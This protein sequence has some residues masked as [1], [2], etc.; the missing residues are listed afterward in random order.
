MSLPKKRKTNIQIKS[1]N[2]D[3]GPA[4]WVEQFIDQN[5]QFL[6]RSV[7]HEDL[8]GGL[9]NFI[10]KDLDLSFDNKVPVIFLTAQRWS[11]FAK[12]WRFVDKYKNIKIPF[13]SI[14]RKPDAQPGTNPADFKIPIRK[15]FPYM[16]IPVWDGN[17]KG[18]DIYRIPNPVGVDLTYTVRFF[19]YKMRQ[20]NTFN[21]MILQAFASAQAYINV[22][23]HYFPIMLESIGDESTVDGIEN[24]RFY[25]QTYEMKLM[26]YLVDE[27]EFDVV[28]AINRIVVTTEVDKKKPKAIVNFI[29][30]EDE[31]DKTVS[32]IIQFLPG[33]PTEVT[34][35]LDNNITFN[36]IAKTNINTVTLKLDGG[37]VTTPFSGDVNQLLNISI[38]RTDS[39]K[40]SE[41]ILSGMIRN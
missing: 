13:I 5:K 15:K 29:S 14:V 21:K 4:L 40:L 31:K 30:S 1:E 27:E 17:R 23:G 9:V 19:T 26:G 32:C 6:P 7:N 34:I 39:T 18:M 38:V 20:L 10:D 22:K 28:P 35:P 3:R 24:K 2:P 25:V 16:S 37:T 33:S 8:D 12:T 11:E 36:T 41:I